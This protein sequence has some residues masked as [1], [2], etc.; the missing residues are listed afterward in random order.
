MPVLCPWRRTVLLARPLTTF[1]LFVTGASRARHVQEVRGAVAGAH[2]VSSPEFLFAYDSVADLSA[3]CIPSRPRIGLHSSSGAPSQSTNSWRRSGKAASAAS[4]SRS[5]RALTWHCIPASPSAPGSCGKKQ[6]CFCVFSL[7]M[8]AWL[9][10]RF[11][12]ALEYLH[13]AGNA[14]QHVYVT[15]F[16]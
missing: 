4:P 6:V 9:R 11:G 13:A 16:L 12:E 2:A 1:N 8:R 3:F 10:R 15:V 5:P 7:F 14:L